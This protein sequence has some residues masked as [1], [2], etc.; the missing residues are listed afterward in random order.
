MNDLADRSPFETSFKLPAPLAWRIAQGVLRDARA[1][2]GDLAD[3]A[4]PSERRGRLLAAVGELPTDQREAVLLAFGGGLTAGQIAS[5]RNL[6]L[7][8]AKSRIRLGLA[9]ARA[10]LGEAA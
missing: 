8:T 6:P 4:L 5:C 3:A 1:P 9:K 10:Q 2:T 7:G